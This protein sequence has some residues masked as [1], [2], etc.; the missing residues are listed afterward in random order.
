MNNPILE[1]IHTLGDL[2]AAMKKAG[3]KAL[4]VVKQKRGSWTADLESIE[5]QAKVDSDSSLVTVVSDD[6]TEMQYPVGQITVGTADSV[7][8]AAE[9]EVEPEVKTRE[10]KAVNLLV[11]QMGLSGEWVDDDR[12]Q[13]TK[14]G[15]QGDVK[16]YAAALAVKLSRMGIKASW[17]DRFVILERVEGMQ[18]IPTYEEFKL[19]RVNEAHGVSFASL[20]GIEAAVAADCTG[21]LEAIGA[22]DAGS[23]F[24]ASQ[25]DDADL[26]ASVERDGT[27]TLQE[28][29]LS[30]YEYQGERPCVVEDDGHKYL[31]VRKQRLKKIAEAYSPVVETVIMRPT[32]PKFDVTT[33]KRSVAG[34]LEELIGHMGAMEEPAIRAAFTEILTSPD[35]HASP[36]TRAKWTD[37][38]RKAVGKKSLMFLITNVYMGGANLRVPDNA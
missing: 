15:A 30:V 7:Q 20:S 1:S 37:A 16:A 23:L 10:Q 6:G 5:A 26:I 9:V 33:S 2:L 4:A 14:G 11:D 24:V 3:P 36:Q 21:L 18:Y 28:G 13:L 19:A 8:E 35:T 38:M 27:L 12:F 25:A 34:K 32:A 22:D 31:F 17:K 29:A